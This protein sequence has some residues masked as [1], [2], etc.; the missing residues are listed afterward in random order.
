MNS[1]KACAECGVSFEKPRKYSARQWEARQFC[2]LSCHMERRERSDR[3]PLEEAFWSYVDKGHGCWEWKGPINNNGYGVFW[4]AGK[5]A[6]A[7]VQSLRLSGATVED[8]ALACHH[9]DN[10]RC[11]RTDHLYAGTY[12]TNAKDARDRDRHTRGEKVGLSKLTE[13][14]VRLIRS[15]NLSGVEL[16]K[17]FDVSPSAISAVRT[18]NTWGHV[19]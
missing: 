5:R 6:S 16:S 10:R 3:L 12:A 11:V 14:D 17:R 4:Y 18:G 13:N 19:R 2:S 15:S 1:V 7:H 8:G 9:C